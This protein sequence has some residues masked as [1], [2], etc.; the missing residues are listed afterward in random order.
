MVCSSKPKEIYKLEVS[1][2]GTKKEARENRRERE[3]L[4]ASKCE[5]TNDLKTLDQVNLKITDKVHEGGVIDH[6]N[7]TMQIKNKECY[8]LYN[9]EGVSLIRVG[10][11]EAGENNKAACL[12]KI[13]EGIMKLPSKTDSGI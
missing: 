8:D 5:S 12:Q 9:L 3:K 11:Y 10:I 4:V 7:K 1:I 13:K 2:D 6:K